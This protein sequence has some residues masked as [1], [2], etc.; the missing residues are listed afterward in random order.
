[1]DAK[2]K[3]RR[4]SVRAHQPQ[5]GI[6]LGLLPSPAPAYASRVRERKVITVLF[7]DLVGFTATAEELDPEDVEKIL[8]PYHE[9][10]R[11]ELERWGGTVEKFIGDAVMALFGAPVT[12]E[13]DPERA[14]R[15]ALAIRDWIAEEGKLELRIAVNTGEALVNL[16]AKPEAGEGMATGDVV[17]TASRL[18][19]A[20][21]VN[22]I[23]VGETTYR[24][25]AETIEYREHRPVEAKGKQA[26]VRVWEVAQARARFGVDL[27]P[28]ERTPLV[29]RDREVA[30]LV[31][32][33]GRVRD[34]RSSELLTL[35]G[36]PGIGKSRLVGELFQAVDRG[37]ALTL[38]RQ[39]R[40]LPYG[41]GVSYWA[42]AEMVK[43]QAGIL[44]TDSEDE[45]EAKLAGAVDRLVEEDADW[46]VAQLRPLVGQGDAAGTQEESFAAWRRFF[47]AMAEQRPLVLVFEDLQWA[48]D[49]LLDFVEHLA[50]WVRDAPMLIVCTARPELLER[51]PM[52]GGGK[53]NATTL[54]LAPLSDA[55][56]SQLLAGLG[57]QTE[58]GL[59]ERAGG[60]PLYAEQFVRMLAERGEAE[61]ALPESVQGI[62]AARLDSLGAKEKALLQDAA[63]LGK[64]F[65]LGALG[66]NEQQLHVLRQKE[67]VQRARRSS[68]EGE[69]EYAFKHVLV[70]DVAYGQIPRAERAQKHL[71][72][73]D[74]IESLGRSEDHAEMVAHHCV[75]ALELARAAGEDGDPARAVR[76]LRD[77]GERALTL[78][79]LRQAEGYYRQAVAL[80]PNDP[81]ILLRYGRVLY[82]RDEQGE[83]ELTRAR[84]DLLAVGNV[85]AAAEATLMLADIAWKQGRRKDMESL[86]EEARSFV[87]E[88]PASRAQA[89]VMTE[90]AR[91]E[92]IAGRLESALEIGLQALAMAEELELDDL[93]LRAM[94]TVGVSRG[95][96]GD[97]AGFAQLQDVIEL[98]TRMNA[99]TEVI[100][101]WNNRTALYILHGDLEQTRK[102][103]A[104]TLRLAR[105]YGQDGFIRF[106]EGGAAIG[107]RFHAGEWDAA[108]ARADKVI[109]NIERGIP[110]YSTASFGF[111]SLIRLARGDD[112]G[113]RADA[114]TAAVRAASI[115]DTQALN[116][117]LAVIA[118][119]FISVGN[120][121]RAGE[122]ITKAL[123]N[124]RQLGRLGFGVMESPLLA[125]TALKLGREGEVV[126]VLDR[127][128]FKSPWL[129]ASLAVAERDFSGAADI[130]GEGGIRS[131]EAFF[132]LQSGREDDVRRAV[133]FY[134]EVHATRYLREADAILAALA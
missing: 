79:A 23:L 71:R 40:S 31:D 59:L 120:T 93:R 16:D 28:E 17:N 57:V 19:S 85:E 111:R 104:E 94:N 65:W 25:T 81:E 91:Y 14:V 129:R 29:G 87:A 127:E 12:R 99:M 98:A 53:P 20:S 26:P 83:D 45:V 114:E 58:S 130:L 119:V 41:T 21:P 38:W 122:M 55:E 48:D 75:N 84:S 43:A 110:A 22:G 9:R 63:V 73:A 66:A 39:G 64:V 5:D 70:R 56:T 102:G 133:D 6:G 2:L 62:I 116:P 92:M 118:L 52:W 42:L 54:T 131:F 82:L 37:G 72:A 100:R 89:S 108:L 86:V 33:L 10:L 121:E 95:D 30:Q 107:N 47:E 77:A 112:P 36:V 51:R 134:S 115:G 105:N 8:R 113:A 132:Q 46:V 67:F 35:V 80:A 78:N 103:E 128:P 11:Y 101:G 74:W 117:V 3:R 44:E 90:V 24:A 18:Q 61:G 27:A 15:A 1:V 60:N 123:D 4:K 97:E 109:G 124:L 49:G 96:M 7:A 126:E 50:D 125:W 32:A 69:V 34:Q 88:L 68:V 76:A 13:D 106:V